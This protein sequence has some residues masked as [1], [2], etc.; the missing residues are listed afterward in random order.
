MN[1]ER[2]ANL[3]MSS[4]DP[5][6]AQEISD[7]PTHAAAPAYER[8]CCLFLTWDDGM[9][10]KKKQVRTILDHEV[11]VNLIVEIA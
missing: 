8:L 2:A 7:S 3:M 11:D 10:G 1:V 6:S 5:K 9:N 4:Q